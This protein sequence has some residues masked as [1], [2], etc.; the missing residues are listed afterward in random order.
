MFF[1]LFKILWSSR[2]IFYILLLID[3]SVKT[4]PYITTLTKFTTVTA[5]VTVITVTD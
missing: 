1:I 2:F 3:L 4:A 5:V